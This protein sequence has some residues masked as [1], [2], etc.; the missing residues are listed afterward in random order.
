MTEPEVTHKSCVSK[1]RISAHTENHNRNFVKIQ[2]LLF[3]STLIFRRAK[4]RAH[5]L[6]RGR[7]R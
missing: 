7:K 5:V 3:E 6:L 1:L 2:A 4:Q